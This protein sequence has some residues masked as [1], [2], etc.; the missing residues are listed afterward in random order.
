MN[1]FLLISL[2]LISSAVKAEEWVPQ[3]WAI[4]LKAVPQQS[5][6]QQTHVIPYSGKAPKGY[7]RTVHVEYVWRDTP[8]NLIITWSGDDVWI[9]RCNEDSKE[10]PEASAFLVVKY[11]K[12][13]AGNIG[14]T[15]FICEEFPF[16]DGNIPPAGVYRKQ[17]EIIVIETLDK[18]TRWRFIRPKRIRDLRRNVR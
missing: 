1:K 7:S 9:G 3:K 16:C 4:T 13:G 5:C 14:D 15:T 18:V 17:D 2:I 11:Y 12:L 6:T 8:G 10:I